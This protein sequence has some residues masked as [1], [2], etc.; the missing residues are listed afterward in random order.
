MTFLS[1]QFY[2][3]KVRRIFHTAKSF[4]IRV[5]QIR[6]KGDRRNAAVS[7]LLAYSYPKDDKK[8]N[9]TGA[10]AI[11]GMLMVVRQ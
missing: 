7:L 5:G 11:E 8:M 2:G 1:L 4:F 9:K 6:S 3:A 10:K